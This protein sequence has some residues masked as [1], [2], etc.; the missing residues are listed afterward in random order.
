[1]LNTAIL[2]DN[3]YIDLTEDVVIPLNKQLVDI[4]DVGARL[5]DFSK[6]IK[7]V[8]TT[9]NN[10]IFNNIWDPRIQSDSD[11]GTS[12]V[13]YNFNPRKKVP[14]TIL[15]M[16]GIYFSGYMQLLSIE[17]IDGITYY[18]CVVF[19]TLGN[20]IKS[21]GDSKLNELESTDLNHTFS[22][23]N[24]VSGWASAL[25]ESIHYAY[26]I[27][28]YGY[29][30]IYSHS[31]V[32]VTSMHPAVR[33]NWIVKEIIDKAGYSFDSNIIDDTDFK[34]IWVPYNGIGSNGLTATQIGSYSFKQQQPSTITTNYPNGAA[35]TTIDYGSSNIISGASNFSGAEY[36]AQFTGGHSFK[37]ELLID[38]VPSISSPASL[39]KI[40]DATYIKIGYQIRNSGGTVVTS[41][42]FARSKEVRI[43]FNGKSALVISGYD[44]GSIDITGGVEINVDNGLPIVTG[45][46]TMDMTD[47]NLQVGDKVK[48]YVEITSTV[49]N[50][51]RIYD[52][53]NAIYKYG[54]LITH[55]YSGSTSVMTPS[56]RVVEGT[57]MTVSNILSDTVTMR[58][59]FLSF[60]KTFNLVMVELEPENGD[61]VNKVGIYTRDYYMSLGAEKDFSQKLD[62]NKPISIIPVS[63]NNIEKYLFSWKEAPDYFNTVY[64]GEF[65][66]DFG[67]YEA[68]S[69][70]E[71]G[72]ETYTMNLIF[73]PQQVIQLED[74]K[75]YVTVTST[76]DNLIFTVEGIKDATEIT[77]IGQQITINS[78]TRT[79]E[80]I[81]G[82]TITVDSALDSWT[83]LT[84]YYDCYIVNTFD[85]HQMSFYK[86]GDSNITRQVV[87]TNPRL[88]I[89]SGMESCKDFIVTGATNSSTKN[90]Y[91]YF[92][93]VNDKDTPSFDMN[94]GEPK[95]LNFP[96]PDGVSYPVSNMYTEYHQNMII[97][98]ADRNSK[99]LTAYF[100]LSPIDI[101]NL[102]YNDIIFIDGVKFRFSRVIDFDLNS[103]ESIK[104]ELFQ[105]NT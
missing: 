46:V 13:F 9:R 84:R 68:T 29:E 79:I 25:S 82:N 2:L 90:T 48:V 11:I 23:S 87:A 4:T 22:V 60:L 69:N 72:S 70:S 59:F 104:L 76:A 50:Y 57:S 6:T 42:R 92:S 36:I 99:I 94:W 35:S 5:T 56:S 77:G 7:I 41:S 97:E 49:S 21:L 65:D 34:K 30:N 43:A 38:V 63:D 3:Y 16:G 85:R 33:L 58:D 40:Q 44:S 81:S 19:G 47:V 31:K 18:D 95:V 74:N 78:Y 17:I 1:M 26:P 103:N 88:V 80:K 28:D 98:V 86:S 15:Y 71:F 12:R 51:T 83:S 24:V 32:P 61:Y 91:P 64:K 55:I 37:S 101:L 93:H 73:E 62:Y 105:V 75:Y 20:F 96:L 45:K 27:A 100:N 8:G 53:I 67:H 52:D 10:Q 39:D 14:C 66:Y 89:F 102:K 54:T